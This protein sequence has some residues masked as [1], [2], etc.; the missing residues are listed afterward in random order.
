MNAL[1]FQRFPFHPS[2]AAIVSFCFHFSFF[3]QKPLFRIGIVP[4]KN[5]FNASLAF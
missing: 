2:T 4:Q 1:S 5:Q 3:T